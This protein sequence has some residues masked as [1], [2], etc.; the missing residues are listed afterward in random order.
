ME[1][2]FKHRLTVELY[3]EFLKQGYKKRLRKLILL[4]LFVAGSGI[5]LLVSKLRE[6]TLKEFILNDSFW[7]MLSVVLISFPA[8]YYWMIMRSVKNITR[9]NAALFAEMV[10]G[11]SNDCFYVETADG[12]SATT[13]WNSFERIEEQD[14]LYLLS[15]SNQSAHIIDKNQI[16]PNLQASVERILKQA[17]SKKNMLNELS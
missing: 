12:N 6:Y 10:Y 5:Y 4:Y 15:Y 9:D 2:K 11:F 7:F 13:K 3:K 17:A 14:D 16:P 8:I 1:L